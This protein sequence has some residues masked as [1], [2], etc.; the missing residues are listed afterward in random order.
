[1]KALFIL[2]LA[3]LGTFVS[4]VIG[5][6][7]G[8]WATPMAVL[9]IA[10]GL[11]Y[12]SGVIVALFFK[13]SPHTKGGGLSSSVGLKGLFRKFVMIFLVALDYQ[14]D[15]IVGTQNMIRD[16]VAVFFIAN[17]AVSLV[18]IAG[19]MGIPIPRIIL[20][21]IEVLKGKADAHIADVE[22]H[23]DKPPDEDLDDEK[24]G[25]GDE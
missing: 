17:E 14:L 7:F 18:E 5:I 15:K 22:S 10:I 23:S 9:L 24:D 3:A 1:M 2:I 25:E 20:T 13:K 21:G 8:G 4:G 11:D 6:L 19:L 16:A 12:A